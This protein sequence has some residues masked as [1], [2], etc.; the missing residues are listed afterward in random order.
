MNS[1]NPTAEP[2]TW[3][4]Q[5][6]LGFAAMDALHEEF[7]DVVAQL[8]KCEDGELI[9]HLD[10]FIEHAVVHFG[11]E[12][13]WMRATD[14]PPRECHIDEHAAVM[15]SAREV[16]QKTAE[17]NVTLA[18]EF[19]EELACW[20]PAHVD[21]LDS[22]LAHWMVKRQYGGKPVVFRRSAMRSRSSPHD[23][24]LAPTPS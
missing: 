24:V 12:D 20:F 17:G 22:A 14:F 4:D 8:L 2:L 13:A 18:R 6:L 15:A 11:D 3:D 7:V 10:R 19:A 21:H 1:I 23:G 5:Y 9:R 16:R